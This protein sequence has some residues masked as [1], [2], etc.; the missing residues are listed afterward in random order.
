[1]VKEVIRTDKLGKHKTLILMVGLP[2]SGKSTK[3]KSCSYPKVNPDS[4]RMSLHG[5]TFLSSM[6][7]YVWAITRTMIESLFHAGHDYVILDA[8]NVTKRRR[9]EWLSKKWDTK[10]WWVKTTEDVCLERAQQKDDFNM[11]PVIKRMAKNF[12]PLDSNELKK[13]IILA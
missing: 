1:M 10:F 11:V 4:I 2:Y 13:T 8:T 3:L 12:E 9:N 6:E 5:K 7:P